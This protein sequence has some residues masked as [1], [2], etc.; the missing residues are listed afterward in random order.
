L[1]VKPDIAVYQFSGQGTA[2][3]GYVVQERRHDWPGVIPDPPGGSTAEKIR[4]RNFYGVVNMS[5]D[6]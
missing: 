1:A 6:H 4:D 5:L 3:K 2:G